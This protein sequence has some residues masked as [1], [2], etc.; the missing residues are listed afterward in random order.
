MSV[1]HTRPGRYQQ[2]AKT[3]FLTLADLQY[4]ESLP[5]SGRPSK[6]SIGDLASLAHYDSS[7]PSV[8]VNRCGE[9]PYS[10]G[11]TK[12]ECELCS[13][14]A[15]RILLRPH[16]WELRRRWRA[17]VRDYSLPHRVTVSRHVVGRV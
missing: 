2:R 12:R 15:D 13:N 3:A 11:A 4:L 16:E 8:S 5:E 9:R 6:I 1:N 17:E 10:G 14:D 7:A